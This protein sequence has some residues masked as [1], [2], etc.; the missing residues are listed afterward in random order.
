MQLCRVR[1][2]LDAARQLGLTGG[3]REDG[4]MR[5][6]SGATRWKGMKVVGKEKLARVMRINPS[7]PQLSLFVGGRQ[8]SP[9]VRREDL[10]CNLKSQPLLEGSCLPFEL[11]LQVVWHNAGDI[12]T[13]RNMCLVSREMHT[14]TIEVLFC[15]LRFSQH[16]DFELWWSMLRRMPSLATIPRRVTI[17]RSVSADPYLLK[18]LLTVDEVVWA[19][20]IFGWRADVALE[21][22]ERIFPNAT[23]VCFRGVLFRDSQS[24]T[25]VLAHFKPLRGL[26]IVSSQLN[27]AEDMANLVDLSQLEELVLT[28]ASD[29]HGTLLRLLETSSPREL[30][31]L[32]LLS[33]D[34]GRLSLPPD[35]SITTKLL[36]VAAP[37]LQELWLQSEYRPYDENETTLHAASNLTFPAMHTLTLYIT[38]WRTHPES[39]LESLPPQPSITTLALRMRVSGTQSERESRNLALLSMFPMQF[40]TAALQH[41]FPHLEHVL[42]VLYASKSTSMHDLKLGAREYRST[43]EARIWARLDEM[44]VGEWVTRRVKIQ[45][46]DLQWRRVELPSS[47]WV[48]TD[49]GGREDGKSKKRKSILGVV[50]KLFSKAD[51]R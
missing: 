46:M 21:Y 19:D 5:P 4:L 44:C 15:N 48:A 11:A 1:R 2:G 38:P 28:N 31:V 17:S 40:T 23:R 33:E 8:W 29:K 9:S 51:S 32:R 16:E 12:P 20:Y 24:F 41:S 22:L 27:F 7:S 35:V 34:H 10:E 45:W 36:Q 37:S 14:S 30:R 49:G 42:I 6:C 39:F 3:T 25:S 26:S 47:P 13:L 18:P 50:A 43:M